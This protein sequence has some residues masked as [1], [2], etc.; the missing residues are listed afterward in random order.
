MLRILVAEDHEGVRNALVE[1]LSYF[2]D[3]E[4][5][6]TAADGIDA[7]NLLREHKADVVLMDIQ[8]P[9]M[10]GIEATLIIKSEH[11][12][13]KIV[14]TTV[15]DDNEHIFHAIRAG[16]DGYLL[17]DAD[18]GLLYDAL[19]EVS[20][21]GAPMSPNVARKALQLLRSGAE[22]V[23]PDSASAREVLTEREMEILKEL[24][25]GRV[26]TEIAD[27]LFIAPGTVRKHVENIY[28]KLQVHSKVEAVEQARKRGL[29]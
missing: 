8:M 6:G 28:R 13:T 3:V 19:Q 21:G 4:L 23:R 5:V 1:K 20:A 26:Y 17:K 22:P 18:P 15:M 10:D 12:E 9:N 27:A 14:M 11:P 24:S 25:F 2:D 16:A 7:I 29:F